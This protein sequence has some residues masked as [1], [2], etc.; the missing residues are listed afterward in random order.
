MQKGISL[1]PGMGYPLSASL[2]YLRLAREAGFTRLFTSL[3]IPE[4]D[5]ATLLEEFR[6]IAAAA[7]AL[8]FSITADISPG[9]FR[10]LDAGLENLDPLRALRLDALRLDF[11]FSPA[12]I[13]CWTRETGFCIE[14]NASTLERSTLDAILASGA[15]ASRLQAC[16]NYYPRP[17]TGL[18]WALFRER[19]LMFR[20]RDIPVAAFIPSLKNP[21]GPLAE[22]LP[23]LECHRRV[24]ALTAVKQLAYSGLVDSIMFGDPLAGQDEIQEAGAIEPACIEIRIIPANNLSPAEQT[25]LFVEHKKPH[26]SGRM[27]GAVGTVKKYQSRRGSTSPTDSTPPWQRDCR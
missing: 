4:A 6:Q 18:S 14:L 15:D 25:I 5:G 12:E 16:H 7:A 21:R 9:T 8:G 23:T 19:S 2:D 27:G 20:E 17:E 1:F 22:G 11:G 24:K 26:R 3:H 10:L 13:A